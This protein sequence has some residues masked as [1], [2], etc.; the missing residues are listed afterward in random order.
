VQLQRILQPQAKLRCAGGIRVEA[1]RQRDLARG[2]RVLIA[3]QATPLSHCQDNCA[4]LRD[5][6]ALVES[7]KARGGRKGNAEVPPQ[8]FPIALKRL[9]GITV[10]GAGQ[11]SGRSCI[12]ASAVTTDAASSSS[13]SPDSEIVLN[14]RPASSSDS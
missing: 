6:P 7:R 10:Y 13:S 11:D 8:V 14:S 5:V 9:Q 1:H 12:V 2:L 3:P 4:K